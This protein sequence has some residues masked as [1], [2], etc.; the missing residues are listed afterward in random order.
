MEA[1]VVPEHNIKIHFIQVAGVRGN[2]VF[3]LVAAP[4]ML[5]NALWQAITILHETK[6]N[7]VLGM[8]DMPVAPAVLQHGYWA[9]LWYCMNKTPRQVFTN[10]ILAF[11]AR[12]VLTGF[13]IPNWRV[14][15]GK[16]KQVGNPVR[17]A[18]SHVSEKLT[19]NSPLHILVCGGS[20]GARALNHIVPEAIGL[21]TQT[22]TRDNRAHIW[23]QTGKGNQE[24]VQ[25]AY[26]DLG[27][28]HEEVK[29]TEFITEM[30]KAYDWADL[31]IC[32]S[33][34][35]TVSEVALAGRCAIFVPLPHAV[36][37]HQTHNAKYLESDGAAIIIAQKD[38][39][40]HSLGALLEDL[41]NH[42]SKIVEMSTN[43]KRLGVHDATGVVAQICDKE[44]SCKI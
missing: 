4:F 15:G 34:A 25:Q 30:D 1:K 44:A 22:G 26:K 11:L 33:G 17:A 39:T 36:D 13:A 23:H 2:G 24:S 6:P 8:E 28:Q 20:L 31:V 21:F 40:P 7:V 12:K 29:V 18:F 41:N 9:Y 3:K 14:R 42:Q 27:I 5:I 37:D 35:L 16:K 43:A 38:L 19:V 10:K 32:R